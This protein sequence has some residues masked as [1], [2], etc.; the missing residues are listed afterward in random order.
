LSQTT[1]H[2]TLEEIPTNS[3]ISERSLQVKTCAALFVIDI[4]Y[5]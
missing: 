4:A 2:V 3:L 1:I 5:C